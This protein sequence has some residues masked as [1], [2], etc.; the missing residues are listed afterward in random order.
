M[1]IPSFSQL[2]DRSDFIVRESDVAIKHFTI[3]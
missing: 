1:D 3:A 2:L